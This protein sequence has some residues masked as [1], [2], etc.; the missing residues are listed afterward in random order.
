MK[1]KEEH[2]SLARL[3]NNLSNDPNIQLASEIQ[4]V[5]KALET[6]DPSIEPLKERVLQAAHAALNNNRAAVSQS[7]AREIFKNV[8]DGLASAAQIGKKI[9][10]HVEVTTNALA[11]GLT[12]FLVCSPFSRLQA[13]PMRG[14]SGASTTLKLRIP[15]LG[16]RVTFRLKGARGEK[17]FARVISVNDATVS[18]IL[19]GG[20]VVAGGNVVGRFADGHVEFATSALAGQFGLRD[21]EGMPVETVV[22][23]AT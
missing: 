1:T 5:R 10:D 15:T 8:K 21:S 6:E 3:I 17:I 11:A 14:G 22:E 13:V 19:D 2:K 20:I 12:D 18:H 4:A 23:N 16:V 9:A 7:P